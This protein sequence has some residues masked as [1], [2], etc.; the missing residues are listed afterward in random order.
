[1]QFEQTVRRPPFNANQPVVP[2]EANLKAG[3]TVSSR[4]E[5]GISRTYQD[6]A[7]HY[8]TAILPARMR[9]PRYKAKVEVAVQVV[10]RWLLA[11]SRN[12]WFFSLAELDVAIRESS[13]T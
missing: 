4:Y 5:P 11:R 10:Q 9:K 13:S 8:G 12:R 7:T 1:M 2:T 3:V 6:M